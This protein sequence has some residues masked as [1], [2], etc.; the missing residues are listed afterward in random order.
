MYRFDTRAINEPEKGGRKGIWQREK[1]K[2]GGMGTA[3]P[4]VELLN[5]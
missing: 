1:E 3:L 5:S 2:L 4:P